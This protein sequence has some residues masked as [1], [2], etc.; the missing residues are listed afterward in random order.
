MKELS[1]LATGIGSLPHTDA[2]EAVDLVLKYCPQVPFWPQLPRRDAREGMI[3]QFSEGL[4]CLEL[5]AQG[6]VF[7]E[8]DKEGGWRSSTRRL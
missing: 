1:G 5:A 7:N 8:K 3:A 4:P 2:E 6:V